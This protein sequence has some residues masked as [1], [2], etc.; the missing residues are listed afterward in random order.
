VHLEDLSTGGTV[1]YDLVTPEEVDPRNGKISVSSPIGSA[2]LNKA[3]GATVVVKLPSGVKEYEITE[4]HT[5]HSL[6]LTEPD[7]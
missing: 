4:F 1:V 2:L 3:E 6:L 5:I 7:G